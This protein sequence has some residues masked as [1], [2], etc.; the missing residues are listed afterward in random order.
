MK[1]VLVLTISI[2]VLF[3]I[4][5]KKSDS[6]QS[7]L[8]APESRYTNNIKTTPVYLNLETGDSVQVWDIAYV[9][10]ENQRFRV[11][12][13][14]SGSKGFH[15]AQ[16]AQ[17]MTAS[18]SDTAGLNWMVDVN[19]TSGLAIGSKWVDE[20]TLNPNDHYSIAGFDSVSF[21]LRYD[22]YPWIKFQGLF[23]RSGIARFQYTFSDSIS[24]SSG[25]VYWNSTIHLDSITGGVTG[26]P[27]MYRFNSG[28]VESNQWQ[29]ALI[30]A[31]DNGYKFPYGR[32]N[33]STTTEAVWI[34]QAY[35]QVSA[36]PTGVT[37]A[38]DPDDGFQIG[39]IFNY[40]NTRLYAWDKT[41][42]VRQNGHVWKVSFDDYYNSQNASG[43]VTWRFA[44][45]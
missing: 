36:V 8:T 41:L 11:N 3:A 28:M 21:I 7:S 23:C 6:D 33:R 17:S 31:F 39:R 26:T 16:L 13:G 30:A 44:R 34:N 27:K 19:D 45:L 29:I 24:G 25:R 1:K 35:D 43:F 5:C 20:S 4:G 32:L 38:T 10:G 14:S 37:F 9:R 22:A 15:V 2:G 42:L 12:C 18:F 40:I